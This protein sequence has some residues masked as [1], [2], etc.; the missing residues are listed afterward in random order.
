MGDA[1][2]PALQKK[3][4]SVLLAPGYT[5]GVFK[6]NGGTEL[7]EVGYSRQPVTFAVTSLPPILAR[8]AITVVFGP[9]GSNW[10]EITHI[11][12]FDS[13]GALQF[14]RKL[15]LPITKGLGEVLPVSLGAIEVGYA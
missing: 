14:N 11:G 9:A 6:D 2:E 15:L 4:L 1:F 8:N 13:T 7:T 3:M 10:P 5:L 12:V